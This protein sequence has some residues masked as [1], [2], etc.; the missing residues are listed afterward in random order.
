VDDIGSLEMHDRIA[1]S[2]R[3]RTVP[4]ASFSALIST[5]LKSC[6]ALATQ[7]TQSAA[8]TISTRQ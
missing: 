2:V 5:L 4:S 3:R 6:C 1:V 8:N 7:A